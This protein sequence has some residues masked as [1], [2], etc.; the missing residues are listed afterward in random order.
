MFSIIE[1]FKQYSWDEMGL[2]NYANFVRQETENNTKYFSLLR[3]DF[4]VNLLLFM[5]QY[6][7]DLDFVLETLLK[8]NILSCIK[9][10]I[11]N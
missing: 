10:K 8:I 2:I 5:Q 9:Y 6:N 3:F 7:K 1:N 4:I 11:E